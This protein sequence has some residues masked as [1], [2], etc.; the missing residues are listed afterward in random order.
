LE[1]ALAELVETERRIGSQVAAAETEA[2][3]LVESARAQVGSAADDA[4]GALDEALLE[5][6]ESI[7]RECAEAIRSIE[8]R[9]ASEAERYRRVREAEVSRLAEWVVSQLVAGSVGS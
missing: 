3:R 5:L 8:E 2:E 9:A 6:R 1:G 7:E 4:A